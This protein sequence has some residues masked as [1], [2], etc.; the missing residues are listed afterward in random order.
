MLPVNRGSL[1]LRDNW[2]Y[3]WYMYLY[4]CLPNWPTLNFVFEN[5]WDWSLFVIITFTLTMWTSSCVTRHQTDSTL[6]PLVTWSLVLRYWGRQHQMYIFSL[7][8][9]G[10]LV[11]GHVMFKQ[12]FRMLV[13]STSCKKMHNLPTL[14]WLSILFCTVTQATLA[15][16]F[17]HST[18]ASGPPYKILEMDI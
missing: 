6:V 5:F 15:W 10:T 7:S 8:Y 11:G 3:F 2:F 12:C 16:I 13:K 4:Q 1:L 14:G 18:C 9:I 17:N